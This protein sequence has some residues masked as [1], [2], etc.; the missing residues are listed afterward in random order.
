MSVLCKI[1]EVRGFLLLRVDYLAYELTWNTLF[2]KGIN[3]VKS[4]MAK[5]CGHYVRITASMPKGGIGECVGQLCTAVTK[6]SM[7]IT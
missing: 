6:Y 7:Y 1:Y 3:E 5:S 4:H 2:T